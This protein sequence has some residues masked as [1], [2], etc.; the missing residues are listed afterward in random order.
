MATILIVSQR[1]LGHVLPAVGVGKELKKRGHEVWFLGN[2]LNQSLVESAGLA[3]HEIGWD[4]FPEM[5]MEEMASDILAFVKKTPVDLVLCDS[6]QSAPAFVAEKM[7][8]KWASFQ[9]TV[10]LPDHQIPGNPLVNQKMRRKYM[11]ELNQ[12]REGLGLP[13]LEDDR[14]SRGDYA[15]LS[16]HLH[17]VMVLPHMV[18]PDLPSLPPSARIVGPCGQQE[19]APAIRRRENLPNEQTTI[20]ICASSSPRIEYRHIIERYK[21]ASIAAFAEQP[22]RLFVA[23]NQAYTGKEKLPSNVCWRTDHPNH[24]ELMPVA[25]VVVTHGGCGTL[26]TAMRYGVPMVIIPLGADHPRLA[27]R[28]RELGVAI[29]IPPEE[30]SPASI[31]EAVLTIKNN[32]SFQA[33]AF[34]LAQSYEG[35]RPDYI[36]AV[37]VEGLLSAGRGG[38]S[39]ERTAESGSI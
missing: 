4:K 19:S 29:V 38:Q 18:S 23:E 39:N 6:A 21:M 27:E 9:T 7:G 26:Q 3:F 22:C 10:P 24:H 11:K 33:K 8:I 12:V 25:D 31:R 28:C 5:F 36:C 20:V 16:P 35:I 1:M 15:G 14:R 34:Q 13:P 30:V 17:L 2:K 37:H 32:S